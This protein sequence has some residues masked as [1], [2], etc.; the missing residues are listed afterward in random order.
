[1]N[2]FLKYFR[3]HSRIAIAATLFFSETEAQNPIKIKSIIFFSILLAIFVIGNSSAQTVQSPSMNATKFAII[4][5]YGNHS[6]NEEKVRDMIITWGVDFIITVGDNNYPDGEASTIDANIGNFYGNW[7]GNYQGNGSSNKFF[8]SLGNHDWYEPPI[9]DPNIQ[10]YVDYFNLPGDEFTNSSGTERYYDFVWDNIHFFVL[11][12]EGIDPTGEGPDL[13][14]EQWVE[15]QMTFCEK[16]HFHW[17]IVYFHHPPYSTEL[18]DESHGSYTFMQLNFVGFGAHTV[19]AG[20]A[21][22][23]ERLIIDGLVYFIN[24]VGGKDHDASGPPI[25]GSEYIYGSD[26]G[27]QLVAVDGTE[28]KFEFWSIGT[29]N[30]FVP[31]LKDTW[32]I[33]DGNLPVELISFTAGTN[34]SVATLN[35]ETATEINNYGFDIERSDYVS[36]YVTIGFVEGHGNSNSPKQYSFTDINPVGGRVLIYRLKQIDNDGTYEYSDEIEVEIIPDELALYQNYPNPFNPNTKI[37]YQLSKESRVII[38]LYDILGSEVI[39]LLN[40]KKEPGVYE[41]IFNAALL[42]SGTYIYRIIADGF[43]ETKK[44]VLMK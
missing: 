34:K 26:F 5:D 27:A 29:D 11:D 41:V 19:L 10:P 8:P 38:K 36:D 32:T 31:Q 3:I 9:G 18:I 2:L 20:H 14:Q 42:P 24:G 30:S 44:M 7:I 28:M 39:T 33:T 37:K 1:M 13:V 6:G 21:H 15:T 43:I 40:E 22:K 25:A 17:R 12:S 4:G 16:N 35:W 23:Y